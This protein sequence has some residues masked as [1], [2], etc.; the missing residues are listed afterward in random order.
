MRI[1]LQIVTL[2]L[3]VTAGGINANASVPLPILERTNGGSSLA[4][5]LKQIMRRKLARTS[6]R[7]TIRLAHTEL[8]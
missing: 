2:G 1:L 5:L 4:P 7:D 6:V 3:A 8:T